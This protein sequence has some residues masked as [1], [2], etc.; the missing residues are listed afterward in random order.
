MN[1]KQVSQIAGVSVRTLH[2][3]DAIGLLRPTRD[4]ENGYRLYSDTDLDRLQQVLFFKECG[5]SLDK[6][7][8]ILDRPG[9]DSQKAFDLQRKYLLHQR[10]RIDTMLATLEKSVSSLKGEIEMSNKEKFTG[11]ENPYEDEARRLWGDEVVDKSN[12]HL[13]AMPEEER[14]ALPVRMGEIYSALAALMDERP[15]SKTVQ[16][17]IGNLYDFFYQISGMRYSM[18]AFANVGRMYVDDERFT[19][20]IDAFG[21]GLSEFLA[22]AMQCYADNH[23]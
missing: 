8:E 9:F 15:D 16:D 12:A 22:V 2:H 6:I 3:F 1:V 18:E 19:K 10:Q 5:F 14:S 13:E 11:L 20:T 4:P 21:P 7:K 23:Q 17:E